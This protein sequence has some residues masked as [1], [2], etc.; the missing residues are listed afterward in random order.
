MIVSMPPYLREAFLINV[1]RDKSAIEPAL[2][3]QQ[4]NQLLLESDLFDLR[5]RMDTK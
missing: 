4:L 2:A 5:R 3:L 1:G